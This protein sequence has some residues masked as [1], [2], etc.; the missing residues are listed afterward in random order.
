MALRDFRNRHLLTNAAGRAFVR[1]Y[2]RYSPPLAD[3][4]GRHNSLRILTRSALTPI[5]YVV[6][7]PGAFMVL[8]LAGGMFMAGRK[9]RVK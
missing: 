8:L 6:M 5:V 3:F 4:I 1:F 9:V 2:Y 7:Y